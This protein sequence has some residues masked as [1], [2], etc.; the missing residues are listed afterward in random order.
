MAGNNL[1]VD[2]IIESKE[3]LDRLIDCLG[4]LDVFLVG[5][6]CPLTELERREKQ[7]GDRRIGD[8]KRD[9]QT[10][11]TFTTYD[12]EVNSYHSPDIIAA[13]IATAWKQRSYPASFNLLN[14]QR[15]Q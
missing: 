11:H 4:L 3:Q 7:R 2:Y 10:V 6:H 12:F 13:E 8:A 5:V 1:L 14:A 15:N 9:L